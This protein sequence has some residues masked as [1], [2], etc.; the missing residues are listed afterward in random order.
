MA[1]HKWL[2]N[3]I[4]SRK[5]L[6]KKLNTTF[7]FIVINNYIKIIYEITKKKDLFF[8]QL[9]DEWLRL[10]VGA[11]C[12]IHYFRVRERSYIQNMLQ[13][14]YCLLFRSQWNSKTTLKYDFWVWQREGEEKEPRNII[15]F[16]FF[17]YCCC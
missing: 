15:C 6:C 1:K 17:F 14:L 12:E 2:C 4:N 13:S 3:R 11:K 5:L 8:Y 10:G 9:R 16:K 7:S